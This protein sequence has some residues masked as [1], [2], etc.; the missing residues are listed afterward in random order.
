MMMAIE[1]VLPSTHTN[2]Y[3]SRNVF[4]IYVCEWSFKYAIL[5]TYKYLFGFSQLMIFEQIIY[6]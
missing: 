3:N 2:T 1:S 6:H 5:H 4:E